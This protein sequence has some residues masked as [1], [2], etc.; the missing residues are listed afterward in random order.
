MTQPKSQ[1]GRLTAEENVPFYKVETV[2]GG[3]EHCNAGHFWTVT[4]IEEG[5]PIELSQSFH[6]KEIAEDVCDHMN[7]ARDAALAQQKQEMADMATELQRMKAVLGEY[8]WHGETG[9]CYMC[10][11]DKRGGH[12]KNCMFAA[13][14]TDAPAGEDGKR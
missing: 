8:E 14:L 7:E 2:G 1:S 13:L 12:D 9:W 6:D 10:D 4:W 5:E 3:C 11:S